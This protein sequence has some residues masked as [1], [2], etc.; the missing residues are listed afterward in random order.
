MAVGSWVAGQDPSAPSPA[1]VHFSSS[2]TIK[3][4]S[5][6]APRTDL[7]LSTSTEHRKICCSFYGQLR[8]NGTKPPEPNSSADNSVQVQDRYQELHFSKD[9]RN[10]SKMSC[11]DLFTAETSFH[12]HPTST[13][14]MLFLLFL[15]LPSTAPSPAPGTGRGSSTSAPLRICRLGRGWRDLRKHRGKN[16]NCLRESPTAGLIPE[17]WNAMEQSHWLQKKNQTK[18]TTG[19]QS[20]CRW[21]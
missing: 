7:D 21:I 6:T 14:Q 20:L 10:T 3:G 11:A 18:S 19:F 12:T 5:E 8:K 1:R 2:V 13:A 9:N 16:T 15:L 17:P 4:L